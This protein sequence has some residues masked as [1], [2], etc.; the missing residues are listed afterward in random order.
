MRA[1]FL[2]IGVTVLL[3]GCNLAPNY[4]RPGLPVAPSLPTGTSYGPAASTTP[5][6]VP[7]R[8]IVTDEKLRTII[9]RALA[10]NRDL[11]VA[12]ANVASAQATYRVQR[13]SQLPT[14]AAGADASFA[15][16]DGNI[17][18][19]AHSYAANIGVSSF[20]LDLFGRLKNLSK[21][22]FETYLGTEA[23]ARNT[24]I[25]LIGETATAYA[26]LAADEELLAVSKDTVVSA[27]RS[28]KLTVSLNDAGLAGKLDVRSVETIGAQAASD[29]ENATTQ[30]AQDRNALELLVGAPVED[31]LL[32]IS[33]ASLGAGIGKVQV[34]LSSQVL[35]GRPDV[36]EAEH[37]LISANA[38]IGA[39]RAAFFPTISLTSA[40]GFASTAL[41]SLFTGG[42]FAWSAAP[43]ATLRIFGGAN[44]GN[45]A[46]SEAQRD[47][48][49][50]QYEKAVQTAFRE[51]ADALA[52]A[53]TIE[54]QQAAQARLLAAS[55]QSYRLA[56]ARYREGIDT[57][58][59]A[60]DAQRTL[61]SARQTAV[62]T[63]LAAVTI[64]IT[65]YQVIG[66]DSAVSVVPGD[67]ASSN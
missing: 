50:A 64:R 35:L 25:A 57:Y 24:R 40:V 12:A 45:L 56:D 48:Y 9:D 47:L 29:V 3:S 53:G 60:L 58:L 43:S 46:Y 30:V 4:V 34:G 2:T 22:A 16:G 66:G 18:G 1:R 32:P 19:S 5:I 6:G 41:S 13:S 20:E 26:T 38:N 23:G 55:T 21:A 52:R 33:L 59:N 11:R 42:A 63:N 54:R 44:R 27:Q 39:A 17:T 49:V 67:Q 28:L 61:Y 10:N 37:Q 36:I 15:G 31:A 8:D 62:A 14:I 51:V 65:L 7:W